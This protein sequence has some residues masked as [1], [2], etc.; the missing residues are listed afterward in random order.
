MPRPEHTALLR[1]P[2][3]CPLVPADPPCR[4]CFARLNVLDPALRL[5]LAEWLAYHLSAFDYVWPWLK[6]QHVL[7]APLWDGQR[8]AACKRCAVLRCV[9][10]S[11]G[12]PALLPA[13]A[14]RAAGRPGPG[15]PF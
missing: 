12:A 1:A 11:G 4:E 14:A 15:A 13:A 6:W 7:E 8:R 2:H 5:R 10:P 9:P 3:A